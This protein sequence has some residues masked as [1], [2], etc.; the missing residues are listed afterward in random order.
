MTRW[1]MATG[2][3]LIAAGSWLLRTEHVVLTKDSY[4]DN[5]EAVR[6]QA[7][8]QAATLVEQALAVMPDL[9]EFPAELRKH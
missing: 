2:R 5:L 8:D 6:Q 3:R 9:L 4:R 1:R 7:D